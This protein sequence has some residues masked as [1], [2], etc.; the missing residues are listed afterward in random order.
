MSFMAGR[1]TGR[2]SLIPLNYDTMKHVI[3]IIIDQGR[4]LEAFFEV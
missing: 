1:W 2:Y 3:K 4:S